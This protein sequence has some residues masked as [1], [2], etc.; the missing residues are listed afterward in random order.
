MLATRVPAIVRDGCRATDLTD[1]DPE[2]SCD[3]GG[4]DFYLA[5]WGTK[6][7]LLKQMS[8]TRGAA[9]CDILEQAFGD[10]LIG[11]SVIGSGGGCATEPSFAFTNVSL[12]IEG[13]IYVPGGTFADAQDWFRANRPTLPA[14]GIVHG[15]ALD[16]PIGELDLHHLRDRAQRVSYDAL[17][18][19]AEAYTGKLLFYRARV[20]QEAGDGALVLVTR[21]GGIWRDVVFIDYTLLERLIAGDMVE[22]AGVGTGTYD[23]VSVLGTRERVPAI[24]VIDIEVVA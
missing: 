18:R 17:S 1:A 3:A 6:A 7:R 9:E 4:I 15:A 16:P 12:L 21:T 19:R 11:K 20:L 10:I 22:F 14:Q 24:R 5:A 13:S 8:D 23:Y 2:V